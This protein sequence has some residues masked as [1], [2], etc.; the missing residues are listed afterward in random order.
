LVKGPRWTEERAAARHRGLLKKVQ[1]RRV[2]QY[3]IAG[4]PAQSVILQLSS[5]PDQ[6]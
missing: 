5:R 1:L 2:A 4:T 6:M 3:P